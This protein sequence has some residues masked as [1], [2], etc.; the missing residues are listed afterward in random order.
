MIG[1]RTPTRS[2]AT[3]VPVEGSCA[4]RTCSDP[5]AP[6]QVK[7]TSPS[8]VSKRAAAVHSLYVKSPVT[9]RK[10]MAAPVPSTALHCRARQVLEEHRALLVGRQ[11]DLHRRLV[12]P[13]DGVLLGQRAQHA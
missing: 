8:P 1:A 12:D 5:V 7:V 13:E 10:S 11:V 2:P 9:D 6:W 4:I 3:K